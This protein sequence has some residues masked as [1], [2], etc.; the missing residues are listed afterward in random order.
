MSE[1]RPPYKRLGQLEETSVLDRMDR[2]LK[3][4]RNWIWSDGLRIVKLADRVCDLEREMAELKAT[5]E[6]I[7]TPGVN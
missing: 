3:V 6:R 7:T 4:H 2:A 1:E 5:L